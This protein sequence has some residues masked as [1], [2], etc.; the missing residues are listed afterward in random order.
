MG[1]FEQRIS[2]IIKD[3]NE[4]VKD[5]NYLFDL[6]VKTIELGQLISAINEFDSGLEKISETNTI[7]EEI[8]FSQIEP[9]INNFN[10][11]YQSNLFVELEKPICSYGGIYKECCDD[12]C[13]NDSS[14][15]PI[16][17]IHGHSFNSAISADKSLGDLRELQEKLFLEAVKRL[18]FLVLFVSFST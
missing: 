9:L 7:F 11:S 3:H 2:E 14:K 6:D 17:L 5:L 13:S 16:I 4:F 1:I 10:E 8:N 15:Y 12:F 18:S